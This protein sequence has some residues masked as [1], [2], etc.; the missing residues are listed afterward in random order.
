MRAL[1]FLFALSLCFF[2][3]SSGHAGNPF[4][5]PSKS[6][7]VDSNKATPLNPVYIKLAQVQ[8]QLSGKLSGLMREVKSTG[9]FFKLLPLILIAFFYGIIHA[10]G[11]GHGKAVAASFLISRGR[12]VRDGFFF[13]S[14]IALLHGLSGIAIVLFLKII[15]R[16]S[17]MSPLADITH[18]TKITSY[19]LILGIGILLT[20]KNLYS[21]Y[22]NMGVKRDL[23]SGKYD[24]RPTGSLTIALIVGMIPCPGTVIIMLFALSVD[25]I[26]TGIIL[27][28]S[29]TL[30]MAV[31]ISL[32]GMIVVG[33]KKQTINTLDYKQRDIADTIERFIE[34]GAS[35]AVAVIGTL[36]LLNTI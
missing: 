4:Q 24:E 21:W 34:T 27:S 31:T 22:L 35:S 33:L 1:I 29:Q 5:A 23:Y 11:P 15:L 16:K 7:T 18:I 36:L 9:D 14:F 3:T 32:I 6:N 25:M 19:S 28:I 10:A 2:F 17:V 12:K 30:G 13:G 20:L 26:G 8:Q